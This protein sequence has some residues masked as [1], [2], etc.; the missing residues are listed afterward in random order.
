MTDR[1][2]ERSPNTEMVRERMTGRQT[3][4][5]PNTERVRERMTG[6]QTERSP[7]TEMAR[8]RMTGRQTDREVSQY[9]EGQREND[10]QTDR[11][12]SHQSR[13]PMLFYNHQ[14]QEPQQ[15]VPSVC[16]SFRHCRLADR[17]YRQ[18]VDPSVTAALQTDMAGG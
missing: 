17:L 14:K 3:E 11:E 8:E 6:R 16:R 2:T 1:Q 18:S 10:R 4:R 9:R 7:M 13:R 5:S 12:V 15:I